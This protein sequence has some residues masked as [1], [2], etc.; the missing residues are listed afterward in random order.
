MAGAS[1]PMI[2]AH[3]GC[4]SAPDNTVQSFLEGIQLGADVVEVDLRVTKDGTVVLLH[5]DHPYLHE[6]TY[7]QLNQY[8]VRTKVSLIYEQHE[9]VR[10]T[11]ILQ[12]AMQ[13]NVKLNLDIKT[14][15]AIEPTIRLVKQFGA[16]AQV[17][18]TGC[19]D[20]VT[21]RH[22]DIQVV[23]NTPNEFTAIETVD[24][25]LYAVKVCK[26]AVLGS[27]YGL[28]MDYRTCRQELVELAHS[29][30]LAVWVY[31]V[32]NSEDMDL[33]I[34]IGVDAI[35]TKE[36]TALVEFKKRAASD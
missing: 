10:L 30:G 35:T 22:S 23:Y 3:T 13:R 27:Y 8:E 4:G 26:E 11:D 19:S 18:I 20:N 32:N 9:I 33:F 1:F 29:F 31:T 6:C 14:P 24:Y 16:V 25:P 15:A 17:F 34:R 21:N 5:D 28:N 2:A 7:E 12:I 36:V